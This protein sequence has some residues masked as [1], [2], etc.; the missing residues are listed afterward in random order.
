MT[1]RAALIEAA[2][3]AFK[4]GFDGVLHIEPAGCERFSIDG[5]GATC[6]IEAAPDDETPADAAWRAKPDT[7]LEIFLRKRALQHAY[8]AGRVEIA[9]DMSLMARLQ[10]EAAS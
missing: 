8:L 10:L 4:R 7:L 1:G 3:A 5:R 2:G 9:G 6:L